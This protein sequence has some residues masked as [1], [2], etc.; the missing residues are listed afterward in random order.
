MAVPPANTPTLCGFNRS[1]TR[2]FQTARQQH[3]RRHRPEER[4][5]E[6]VRHHGRPG[7]AQPLL[8]RFQPRV[9]APLSCRTAYLYRTDSV[10]RLR[11]RAT[12]V[13]HPRG[14]SRRGCG[15]R[16]QRG[17]DGVL[18]MCFANR[19]HYADTLVHVHS[20]LGKG[21]VPHDQTTHLNSPLHSPPYERYVVLLGYTERWHYSRWTV[22]YSQS[23]CCLIYCQRFLARMRSAVVLVVCHR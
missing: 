20:Q 14:S 10:R 19:Q 6:Q 4:A 22:T 17:R 2:L 5:S 18:P 7:W 12:V 1:E 9:R 3:P 8:R 23:C 13:L 15:R 11:R 16:R 21:Y